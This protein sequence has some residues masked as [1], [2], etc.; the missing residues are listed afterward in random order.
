M[1]LLTDYNQFAG[2]H[3]ETGTVHNY[4]AYRG[5][6]A[7]H[8]NQPYSEAFLLGVSGG[9]NFG[10]FTFAYDGYDP[11][12]NILTRNTF[13]P[14]DTMLSRLG[15]IQNLQ[16]TASPKRGVDNLVNC[17]D[18]GLP[19]II[20]ADMWSLPYNGLTYDAGMW[21]YFPILVYGYDDETAQIADRA[22][23]PLTSSASALATAR[24]RVKK[25]KHRLL[26]LDP[27]N[28]NKL[29]TAVQL[30]ISDCIKLFTEKPPKGSKNNFGLQAYQF[31]AEL[32]TN[33]KRRKSWAKE[34]PAG[35][36]LYAGLSSAYTFGLTFGKGTTSDGERGIYAEFLEEAA[37][38]LGKPMLNRA[39]NKFR[40][41]GKAWEKLGELLLPAD[42]P[43]AQ[44]RG[45]VDEQRTLFASQ[46]NASL[47]RREEINRQLAQIR[48]QMD[49][50]FPLMPAEVAELQEN[51]AEQLLLIHDIEQSAIEL[52]KQGIT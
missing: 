1:P 49:D 9:I 14:F 34:F 5:V 20:W 17:L 48:Q 4:Y 31:W 25:Y 13:D 12:C 10:Y 46:G 40:E 18:E 19:A 47:P 8:N 28:P 15:V 26:T 41:S 44:I 38:L 43:F 27:P 51:I 22:T 50:D 16:Q 21:G 39:A 37:I 2:T 29:A 6:T 52:M 24:G 30:G 36:K 33:P 32:L 23:V 3:W 7:P 11:Q 42:T 45:L 35:I